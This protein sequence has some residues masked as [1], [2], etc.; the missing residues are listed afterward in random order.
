[1]SGVPAGFAGLGIAF[2]AGNTF[3]AK[4]GHNYDLRQVSFDP[5]N[6]NPAVILQDYVASNQIPNDVTGL[7]V[8][9]GNNILIGTCFNDAPNDLQFYQLTGTTNS[10][11]LFD[12]DFYLSSNPNSQEN[13]VAVIKFPWAF[14]LNVNNGVVAVR[15]AVPP[16]LLRRSVSRP[17]A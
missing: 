8:D 16:R 13:A 5:N 1:M 2:G 17:H 9:A 3:W 7:G 11:I 12:Q 14:G 15:Y 10:P 4:G 6:V